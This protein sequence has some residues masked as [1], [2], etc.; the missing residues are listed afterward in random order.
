MCIERVNNRLFG[1]PIVHGL[2]CTMY[3]V[4]IYVHVYIKLKAVNYTECFDN[5]VIGKMHQR[6][7]SY[8]GSISIIISLVQ[9]GT[10]NKCCKYSMTRRIFKKYNNEWINWV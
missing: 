1:I 4:L 8:Y 9:N 6:K 10:Q 3:N 7:H 2:Y 5:N